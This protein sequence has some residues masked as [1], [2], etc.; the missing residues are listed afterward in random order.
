MALRTDK[1][2]ERLEDDHLSKGVIKDSLGRNQAMYIVS[3]LGIYDAVFQS[4]KKEAK[5][6]RHWVY[7][8]LKEIRKTSGLEGFEI[9]RMMDKEHQKECMSLL[10]N[11]LKNPVRV[12]FIKANTVAN[13]AISNKYGYSKMLKKNDMTPQMLVEREPI[14]ED[15][16]DLMKTKDKFGLDLSVSQLIYQKYS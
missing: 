14:L 5:E 10:Q 13:K 16:V 4:R 6:F 2:K 3:E 7:G 11:G 1:V 9:F 15:T 8:V 12:N